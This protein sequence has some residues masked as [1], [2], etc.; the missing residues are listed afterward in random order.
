MK[1]LYIATIVRKEGNKETFVFKGTFDEVYKTI[2]KYHLKK[3]DSI[4][5]IMEA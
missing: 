3:G 2:K 1:T 5:G 4:K